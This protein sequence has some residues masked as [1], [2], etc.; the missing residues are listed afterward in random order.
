MKRVFDILLDCLAVLIL[1]VP[2]FL[3]TMR[4]LDFQRARLVL[5]CPRWPKQRDLHNAEVS[6]LQVG[7]PTVATY[8]LADARSNLTPIG[9]F[10]ARAVWTSG[11][12]Y[13]AYWLAT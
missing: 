2:V 7:T 4:P 10:C 13:G 5:V 6:Q 3:V 12:S 8:L 9:L 1:F 11:R